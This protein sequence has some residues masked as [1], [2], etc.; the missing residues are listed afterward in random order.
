MIKQQHQNK[1]S[2]AL[3]GALLVGLLSALVVGFSFEVIKYWPLPASV[4][5]TLGF[6]EGLWWGAIAGGLTGL[7]LGF[8]T[9]ESRFQHR[10]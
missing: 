10:Q 5:P 3:L 6:Q 8:L 7:V 9:D 2:T 1:L 4:A